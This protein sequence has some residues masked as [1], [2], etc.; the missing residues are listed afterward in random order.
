MHEPE[1][2]GLDEEYGRGLERLEKAAGE[3]DGDDVLVPEL[4]ALARGKPDR[5]GGIGE[6]LAVEVLQQH[7]EGLVVADEAAAV[8]VAVA[9]AMLQ[10]NA[11]L[12]AAGAGRHTG[13]GRQR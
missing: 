10:R 6:R 1:D 8:N 5:L 12:P 2:P 13:V 9:G 4:V 7:L 3:P 11:P